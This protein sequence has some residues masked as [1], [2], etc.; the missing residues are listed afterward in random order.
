M[1]QRWE[2]C[3]QMSIMRFSDVHLATGLTLL[4]AAY[5]QSHRLTIYHFHAIVYL[6]WTSSSIHL[7]TLI[8]CRDDLRQKPSILYWRLFGMGAVFIMLCVAICLCGSPHWPNSRYIGYGIFFFDA[9]VACTWRYGNFNHLSPD[10]SLAPAL[11][12]WGFLSQLSKLRLVPSGLWTRYMNHMPSSWGRFLSDFCVA[13]ERVATSR[14]QSLLWRSA[15]WTI[16][17]VYLHTRAVYDIYGSV[18][19]ELVWTSLTFVYGVSE[20]FG[21]RRT[22]PLRNYETSW[23]FGQVL[24]VILMLG[25]F[26]AVPETLQ[27]ESCPVCCEPQ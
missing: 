1:P 10:T 19:A 3:C 17:T 24:I 27:G 15:I 5:T 14:W 18:L 16:L 13:R 2:R 11:L 8:I 21:W 22:S 26:L 12:C 6:A 4:I 23:N 20:I 7:L 9:P 25:P